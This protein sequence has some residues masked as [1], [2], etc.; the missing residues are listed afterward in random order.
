MSDRTEALLVSM[1]ERLDTV[2]PTLA[3]KDDIARLEVRIDRLEAEQRLMRA[4]IDALRSRQDDMAEDLIPT[5]DEG[6][7]LD[8]L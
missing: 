6:F 1:M 2:L 5:A 4:D 7:H 8:R 3:T